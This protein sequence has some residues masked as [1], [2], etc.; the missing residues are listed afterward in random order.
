MFRSFLRKHSISEMTFRSDIFPDVNDREFWDAFQND[1]LISLA[2][3]ELEYG[4]PVIKATDFMEFK[5]SGDRRIM[6]IPHFDRRNHLVLFAFA[7]LK[8]NK[9]RFLP[10]I[11]NGIFANCEESFWGDS[12]HQLQIS[13]EYPNIPTKEEQY[14]DLFAAETAEHLA[15]VTAMLREPLERFCPE[16]LDRVQFELDLRIKKP[17]ETR[18]DDWWMGNGTKRPNNWNPWILSNVLTVFLLTEKDERR[19]S[20]AIRKIM[21]ESQNYYNEIPADGGCDEGPLYWGRAGGSLFELLYQLKCATDGAV[22]FFGDEKIKQIAAYMKKAHLVGDVFINVADSH[23]VIGDDY[24]FLLWGFARETAQEELKNLA[25]GA[26][27]RRTKTGEPLT[28]LTRTVRRLVYMAEF[29]REIRAHR[30]IEPIH[31]TVEHLP[32]TELAIL[33]RGDMIL[34]AKGGHNHESHNHNDVGSFSLYDG[35]TPILVDVGIGFYTR[36]HFNHDTRYTLIPWTQAK[37]HN[38]PMINGIDEPCG[39]EYRADSFDVSEEEIRISF[40]KAYPREAL[41]EGLTRSLSLTDG[42]LSVTDRFAFS[43]GAPQQVSEILMCVL[44]VRLENNTAVLGEKY[45]IK[46]SAGSFSC[47]KIA[48]EDDRLQGDWGVEECTR[49]TLHCEGEQNICIE[50]EK[51]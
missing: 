7:E 23:P 2:E 48:F 28:H 4:W 36:F 45:R 35:T 32:E 3:A 19:K 11:V 50:V 16:I 42:G 12:A 25:A 17:Y 39:E 15:T 26:F 40:P 8:E 10:Q 18:L 6:E 14:I 22:N 41:V 27:L 9:G 31:G 44:P 47:E 37:N 30:V 24:L 29:F 21:L 20:R 5:I 51:L 1:E 33:R 46:A 38:L 34:T 13:R 43:T 49:L